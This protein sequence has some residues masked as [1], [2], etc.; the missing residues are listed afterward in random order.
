[1]ASIKHIYW[2]PIMFLALWTI[3]N[4]N[5][6]HLLLLL[7]VLQEW[8]NSVHLQSNQMVSFFSNAIQSYVAKKKKIASG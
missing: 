5:G 6:H 4:Y 3:L 2:V 1:M 7:W 8:L